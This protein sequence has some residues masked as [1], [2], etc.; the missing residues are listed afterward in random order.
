MGNG[1]VVA[2]ERGGVFPQR[3]GHLEEF[4]TRS[5]WHA[6]FPQHVEADQP[7]FDHAGLDRRHVDGVDAP[8]VSEPFRRGGDVLRFLAGGE[9]KA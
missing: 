2:Y 8:G 6:D 9:P 4:G 7:Q 5:A 1:P 3:H